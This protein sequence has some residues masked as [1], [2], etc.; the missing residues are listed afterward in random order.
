MKKKTDKTIKEAGWRHLTAEEKKKFR[1]AYVN[2]FGKVGRPTL[3]SS[4]KK[5]SVHIKLDPEVIKKFKDKAKKTGKPYQTLIN[6]AL[7]KA[8]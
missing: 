4:I 6:E 2:T 3:D 7:K 1:K 5:Q 8:A